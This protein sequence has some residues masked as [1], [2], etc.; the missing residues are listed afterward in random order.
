MM[1]EHVTFSAEVEEAL[2]TGRPTV[3]LE[4]SGIVGGRYPG[5]VEIAQAMDAAV[6]S[7][8][9][10]PARIGI[11]D[12][13]VLVGYEDDAL[14][15]L[16]TDPDARKAG[17]RDLAA[18]L[19]SRSA[20]GL[21]VSGSLV[22]AE[23][24][25]I[26]VLAVAGLG[27]VHRGAETSFDISTDLDEIARRR[28]VVVCAGAKSL[29]DPALTLE[30]LET[31]GVPVIG[32][33][34]SLFPNYLAVSSGYSVPWSVETEGEAVE[35][36]RRHLDLGVASGIVITRPIDEEDALDSDELNS[37][38]QAGIDEARELGLR[39]QDLTPAVLGAV[40]RVTAGRSVAANRA[41]LLS[42]AAAAGRIA[43]EL[44]RV[45]AA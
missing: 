34:S 21:T 33:G 3:A 36:V 28:V 12:G 25:G 17:T 44:S 7:A 1:R 30:Y 37:A 41:V 43:A 13:R 10:V 27:G 22:I 32:L 19:A 42:T 9:A 14:H 38:V 23:S 29:L 31:K 6:R 4:T 39:G 35:I 24:V 26:S 15:E 8:G 16:A 5:N 40:A 18:A 2:R 45:P 20:A 11:R